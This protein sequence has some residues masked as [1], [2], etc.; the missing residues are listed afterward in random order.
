MRNLRVFLVML[1]TGLFLASCA[2]YGSC[3]NSKANKG[4]KSW[5]AKKQKWVKR[6]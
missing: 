2:S 4:I 3:K 6:Y 1:V 5:S